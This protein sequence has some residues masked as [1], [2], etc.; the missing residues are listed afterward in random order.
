[1]HPRTRTH[2][3]QLTH[4]ARKHTPHH[5]PHTQHHHQQQPQQQQPDDVQDKVDDVPLLIFGLMVVGSLS[6][7]LMLMLLEL[8]LLFILRLSSLIVIIGVMLMILMIHTKVALTSFRVSLA[9]LNLFRELS[10]GVSFLLYK[11]ILVFILVLTI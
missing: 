7:I 4:H 9:Q 1:M 11:L 3:T 10:I 8:V 6:H 5:T 2:K